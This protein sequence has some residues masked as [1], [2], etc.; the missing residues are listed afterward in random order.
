MDCSLRGN[1]PFLRRQH[2]SKKAS[3]ASVVRKQRTDKWGQAT[4]LQSLSPSDSLPVLRL[5]LLNV[6]AAILNSCL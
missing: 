3:T 5:Y 4:K 2:S 6:F 1:N